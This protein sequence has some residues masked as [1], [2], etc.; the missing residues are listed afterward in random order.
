VTGKVVSIAETST[1]A[2]SVV[3][4]PVT[5]SIDSPP[6]TLRLGQSANLSVTTAT[7]DNALQV[8]TLA[9]TT[10]GTRQSVTVVKNGTA[11]PT[12]ITTG[13]T[14]NGRTEVLTGLSDGD[15]IE[16]PAIS[17]TLATTSSAGFGGTP[18]GAGG[19]GARGGAGGAGG[20][21]G[22]AGGGGAGGGARGGT[23]PGTGIGQ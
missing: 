3:T 8:P 4:Y 11:T 7:A 5:V 15:Q 10:N 9:I 21:A 1:T 20:G 12:R 23:V 22:G 19:G 17:S 18:F 6:A 16:L 13:I 2:N 14:A